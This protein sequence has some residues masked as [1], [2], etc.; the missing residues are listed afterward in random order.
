MRDAQGE[1][2]YFCGLDLGQAA[3]H[4]ALA[5]LERKAL[6][7]GAPRPVYSLRHLERFE[8]GTSYPA[9][10]RGVSS[11]LNRPPLAQSWTA[12]AVDK[13]G[14][15]AAI[16]DLLRPAFP[17]MATVMITGGKEATAEFGGFRVPKADLVSVLQVL[18]QGRRLKIAAGL[19]AAE[20]LVR[21]LSTFR[22]KVNIA[23]G[24]ES[25]EAWRS[26]DHD[27]MVLAVA[28]AAWL[29]E[30]SAAQETGTDEVMSY[31]TYYT[32]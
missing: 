25:F 22:A 24:N 27:D 23:T 21:E 9:I 12:L 4:T 26:R 31:T 8:L 11:L 29:G 16:T 28:L 18:L 13:T 19:E 17:A 6:F 1:V 20:V 5:V 7:P 10:V 2:R 15:G 30:Y 14:V 32:K 3:D